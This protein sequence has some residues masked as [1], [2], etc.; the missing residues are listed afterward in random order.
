MGLPDQYQLPEQYNDAYRLA[1]DGVVVPVV[2]WL[3]QHP[4]EPALSL[5]AEH[6]VPDPRNNPCPAGWKLHEIGLASALFTEFGGVPTDV[7]DVVL[8]VRMNGANVERKTRLMRNDETLVESG[9]TELTRA[10][11]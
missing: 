1:G 2:S 4:I 9:W 10:S 6:T 3:A 8:E 5:D 7:I 11:R